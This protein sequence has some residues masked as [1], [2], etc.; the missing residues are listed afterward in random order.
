MKS[1]LVTALLQIDQ[2]RLAVCICSVCKE[3]RGSEALPYPTHCF[4]SRFSWHPAWCKQKA[5]REVEHLLHCTGFSVHQSPFLTAWGIKKTAHTINDGG[6]GLLVQG[7][8]I[9]FFFNLYDN[10]IKLLKQ[11]FLSQ[12]AGNV[13]NFFLYCPQNKVTLFPVC[14]DSLIQPPFLGHIWKGRSWL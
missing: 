10:Y 9:S 3:S 13:V 7:I 6:R 2:W 11:Y 12:M 4:S 14:S 8:R 5:G 1:A